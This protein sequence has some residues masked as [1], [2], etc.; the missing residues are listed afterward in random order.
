MV[1]GV[2]EGVADLGDDGEGFFGGDVAG[3]EEVAEGHAVDEFHEEEEDGGGTEGLRRRGTEGG[4]WAL[5]EFVDGDDVGVVELGHGVGFAGETL[6]KAACGGV[7][8][9]FGGED[10]EGDE[11]VEGF[12]AGLVDGAHAAAAEEAGISS[13][14]KRAA[15]WSMAGGVQGNFEFSIFDF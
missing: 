11:A 13:S 9:H 14:G 3:V 15:S 2:L 8:A 4:G 5:S 6:G 7:A 1:V 12:L 10:F